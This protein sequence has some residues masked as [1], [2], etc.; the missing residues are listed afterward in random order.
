MSY[1]DAVM[2]DVRLSV[3]SILS[4]APEG[5][6]G[7]G[8][9][10]RV[11]DEMPSERVARDELEAQVAWLER[12]KLVTTQRISGVTLVQITQRGIDVA[13]GQLSVPGVTSALSKRLN[14]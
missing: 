1:F 11:L 9:L 2:R 4:Q 5:S 14:P 10:D 12:E 6:M 8:L 7:I 3:L 13:S